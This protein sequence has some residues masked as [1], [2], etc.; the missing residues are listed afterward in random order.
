MVPHEAA[1]FSFSVAEQTFVVA[2]AIVTERTVTLLSLR[3]I[4]TGQRLGNYLASIP[5]HRDRRQRSR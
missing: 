3:C 2:D 4:L 1:R 5:V